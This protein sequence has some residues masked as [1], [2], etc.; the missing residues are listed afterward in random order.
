MKKVHSDYRE[1]T[2]IFFLVVKIPYK[3]PG[4]SNVE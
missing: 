4:K 1:L 2:F 3:N